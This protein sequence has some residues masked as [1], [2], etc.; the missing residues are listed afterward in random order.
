MTSDKGPDPRSE[1]PGW[2]GPGDPPPQSSWGQSFGNPSSAS[3]Y[4]SP[5]SGFGSSSAND[6]GSPSSGFGSSSSEYS[7]RG[8]YGESSP[9]GDAG[10]YGDSGSY[11]ESSPY[12]SSTAAPP[13]PGDPGPP[14][15]P[16]APLSGM[17]SGGSYGV[18][19]GSG[20]QT[21]PHMGAG[22]YV[23]APPR[24]KNQGLLIG[25]IA[26]G[27][28]TLIL[29]AALIIMMSSGSGSGP[30]AGGDGQKAA[31]QLKKAGQQLATTAGAQYKGTLNAN[32][33]QSDVDVKV[34]KSGSSTGS[35]T[36]DGKKVSLLNIEGQTYAKGD[37][38]FWTK[39]GVRTSSAS[40]MGDN[41]GRLDSRNASDY[42]FPG[43]GTIAQ[44][45]GQITETQI[46]NTV[47]TN[48]NGVAVSK[49]TTTDNT[50][51]YVSTAERRI[52]RYEKSK[53]GADYSVDLAALAGGQI[54]QLYN[55]LKQTIKGL[56]GARDPNVF[57]AATPKVTFGSRSFASIT[58]KAT[59]T[60]TAVGSAKALRATMT[61]KMSSG[62]R[63]LGGCTGS[64]TIKPSGSTTM[65]CVNRTGKW[66]SWFSFA[67][68]TPGFH[69][70]NARVN[71]VAYAYADADVNA[72]TSKIDAERGGS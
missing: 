53:V 56:K 47:D 16:G 10:S 57:V 67:K 21:G 1:Q 19:S 17:Q 65:S 50:T 36:L 12:A 9:Y 14:P 31:D 63:N 42:Q 7:D 54:E 70:Y 18:P 28:L 43:P 62:S 58:V 61:A 26:G 2:S 35:M 39:L 24:K 32:G 44:T 60:P 71:V 3:D 30:L 4:G 25:G 46:R 8:S 27:V 5:S 22:G 49:I 6:Y 13:L 37:K 64:K 41:W 40:E 11:G 59:V 29:I 45:L 55:D 33:T 66:K 34:T 68:S 69:R 23:P 20:A 52:V 48:L 15:L 38:D 51:Y 72:L